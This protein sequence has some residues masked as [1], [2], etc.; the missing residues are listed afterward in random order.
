MRF[1][2]NNSIEYSVLI[3]GHADSSTHEI[4][5]E[6]QTEEGAT[7]LLSREHLIHVG[8]HGNFKAARD[9]AIGDTVFVTLDFRLRPTKV[10]RVTEVLKRGTYCP[11]TT[12]K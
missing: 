5:V 12:G 6:L 11:H 1:K 4:Y 10:T 2:T 8:H 7:I 3:T 9:V